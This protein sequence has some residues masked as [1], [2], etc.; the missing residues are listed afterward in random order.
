MRRDATATWTMR[1]LHR[2]SFVSIVPLQG[3]L[4]AHHSDICRISE[5]G[6]ILVFNLRVFIKE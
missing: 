6:E 5:S 4:E 3:L 2:V 1:R